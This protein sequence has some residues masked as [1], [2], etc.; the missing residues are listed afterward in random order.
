MRTVQLKTETALNPGRMDEFDDLI[1]LLNDHRRDD[2]LET[3]Q[4]AIFIALSCMGNNHLWQDMMLPN[5]ET[6]SRLM[7][8]HFPALAAKNIGDMKWKKF[9]YRQLCERE[10]ILICKSPSC[11]ICTDYEKCFGPET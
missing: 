2:S 10:N 4:L 6:L 8:T 11:G 3:Q 5:R 1:R 9:F 7:T